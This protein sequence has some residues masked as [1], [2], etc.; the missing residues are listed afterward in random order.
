[1]SEALA[2][3]NQQ[4]IQFYGKVLDQDG[5]PVAGAKVTGGVMV[6][7]KWMNGEITNYYTT[8]GGNGLF[9]FEGLAGRDISIWLEKAG[10]DFRNGDHTLFKYSHLTN[11]TE[12]HTPD[13]NAPVVFTMWK[14]KGPEALVHTKLSRAS[15]P[16]D[17]SPV[18]FDLLTGEKTLAGG[19]LVVKLERNPIHVQR[20]QRF[21]WKATIEVP[22]GGLLE[23]KDTYPNEAPAEGYIPSLI[24]DMPASSADWQSSLSGSFYVRSRGGQNHARLNLRITADYEPPPTALTF[25]AY[26]NPSG[27]RNLEYDHSKDITAQYRQGR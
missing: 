24:I 15:V 26:I 20:G 25:E 14:Q 10:Y 16:V 7:T 9:A 13:V 19:D 21:D 23:I 4:P 1:M 8:T 5:A 12:R 2:V 11:E 17:G 3:L 27:S 22:N 18:A 6:Q